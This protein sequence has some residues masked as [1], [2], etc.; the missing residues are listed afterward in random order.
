MIYFEY[1]F[2]HQARLEYPN[3]IGESKNKHW[4]DVFAKNEDAPN[5]YSGNL[6]WIS[7][8]A[9]A[10]NTYLKSLIVKKDDE[11]LLHSHTETPISDYSGGSFP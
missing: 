8:Q 11:V 6:Y 1:Q 10:D 2:I 5:E 7:D 3:Y 9:K 4:E